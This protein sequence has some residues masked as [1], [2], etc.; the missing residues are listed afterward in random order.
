[1]PALTAVSRSFLI[2]TC[3]KNPPVNASPAPLVS[4]IFSS[5]IMSTRISYVVTTR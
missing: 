4:T 5:A 2:A 1:M 3:D